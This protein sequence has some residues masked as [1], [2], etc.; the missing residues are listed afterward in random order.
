M[1]KS[2]QPIFLCPFRSFIWKKNQKVT[3][4]S[5][6]PEDMTVMH[7]L[8]ASMIHHASE[9]FKVSTCIWLTTIS[10]F[11]FNPKSN[12]GQSL[13]WF[14]FSLPFDS[15][16]KLATPLLTSTIIKMKSNICGFKISLSHSSCGQLICWF[17]LWVCF[18]PCQRVFEDVIFT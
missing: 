5:R 14:F 4:L 3:C 1:E 2:N 9:L 7:K 6:I 8:V 18:G 13:C 11:Q 10:I 15:F 17:I 16:R 12:S